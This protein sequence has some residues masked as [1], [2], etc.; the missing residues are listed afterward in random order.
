M[1]DDLSQGIYPD[2]VTEFDVAQAEEDMHQ[3]ITNYGNLAYLLGQQRAE[4][5]MQEEKTFTV[6]AHFDGMMELTVKAAS[7]EQ[8][9]DMAQHPA[10]QNAWVID[11]STIKI[12]TIWK[13]EEV[14]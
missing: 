6:T 3:A 5:A 12:N 1:N 13:A 9:R 10:F 8:A 2:V 4:A 11:D 14:K 7:A